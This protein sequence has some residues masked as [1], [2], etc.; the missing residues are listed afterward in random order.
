MNGMQLFLSGLP[1][2]QAVQI[3]ALATPQK[4]EHGRFVNTAPEHCNME[5][6]RIEQAQ[7]ENQIAM[8]AFTILFSP[9]KGCMSSYDIVDLWKRFRETI[10][11]SEVLASRYMAQFNHAKVPFVVQDPRDAKDFKGCLL[12]TSPSPRDLSTSRMPSSA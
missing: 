2:H 3:L 7:G 1:T 12:Y 4:D 5:L 10:K 8:D 11:K 9:L 6:M